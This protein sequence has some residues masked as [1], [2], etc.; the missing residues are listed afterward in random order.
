VR[1]FA[2]DLDR[3]LIGT[4]AELHPRTRAA[5][6]AARRAGIHVILVTG[7]MFRSVRPYAE[8]AGIDDPVVCYQGAVVADPVTGQFLRHEPIPLEL[9]R[10]A[11]EAVEAEGYP[12]NCYVDDE[13]YVARHTAAS[14]AYASFQNLE[15]HAVGDLLA[16]LSE[17]PTKLVAVGD[18]VEL[19]GLETRMHARFG[20]RMYISKS[21]PHF[22]EFASPAV[23]KGSGL[24]FLAEHLGFTAAETV[25]FGDGE[26]D[27]ELLEWAGYGVAVENAHER[28]LAVADL[29]CPPVTEEGVAQVIEAYLDSVA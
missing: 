19:D 29:V 12:L 18:P 20:R 24:A 27:V 28:V 17:P 22:L 16:W 1:T 14:E 11:I 10:E 7:R 23:T 9:A 21:L 13:L 25:S 3:T 5:I 8:A 4:D 15:V 26:N 2:C 6:A